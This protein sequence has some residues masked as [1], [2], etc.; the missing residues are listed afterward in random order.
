MRYATVAARWPQQR[1]P[2][3]AQDRGAPAARAAMGRA[4]RPSSEPSDRCSDRKKKITAAME[5][6]G[7]ASPAPD[8]ADDGAD[9]DGSEVLF[10]LPPPAF[11]HGLDDAA[12]AGHAVASDGEEE[13]LTLEENEE[14]EEQE[15]PLRLETNLASLAV[16][17]AER[18]RDDDDHH[19]DDHS[20]DHDDDGFAAAAALA[21]GCG[22][23]EHQHDASA[24]GQQCKICVET[25][26]RE[27]ADSWMRAAQRASRQAAEA[28][29]AREAKVAEQEAAW[30]AA[31]RAVE[32]GRARAEHET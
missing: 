21:L 14:C 2:Q 31:E 18:G 27:A 5:D 11:H 15:E 24:A 8:D 30:R 12:I 26:A 3:A 17:A 32:A 23:C 6:E 20:D 1:V 25:V 28:R 9:S 13:Q 16:V 10:G 19:H 7:A 22:T 4:R 29:A